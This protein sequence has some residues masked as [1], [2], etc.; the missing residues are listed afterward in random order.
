MAKKESTKTNRKR[1]DG[2]IEVMTVYPIWLKR[3]YLS[4]DYICPEPVRLVVHF[5]LNFDGK[6][7]AAAINAQM[8]GNARAI[9]VA[10]Y[11]G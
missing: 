6:E 4:R 3:L 10:R 5:G 8:L 7:D 9:G 1:G 11:W 2:V